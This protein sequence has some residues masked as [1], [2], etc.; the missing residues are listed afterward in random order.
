MALRWISKLLQKRY[1]GYFFAFLSIFAIIHPK[2]P[3]LLKKVIL[4]NIK[5][6]FQLAENQRTMLR[7]NRVNSIFRS[8]AFCNTDPTIQQ[9]LSTNTI[10]LQFRTRLELSRRKWT[11]FLQLFWQPFTIVFSTFQVFLGFQTFEEKNTRL[12]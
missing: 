6:R 2:K 10:T 4:H 5:H 3:H 7:H 8:R 1:Y 9:K 11:N 12:K